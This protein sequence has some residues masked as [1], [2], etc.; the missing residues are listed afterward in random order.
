M[1]KKQVSPIEGMQN[2]GTPRWIKWFLGF[3][4][5][6]CIT[7]GIIL[8][9]ILPALLISLTQSTSDTTISTA[10]AGSGNT[11]TTAS[12]TV[13]NTGS[14]TVSVRYTIL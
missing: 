7:S 6:L 12:S 14:G 10:I 8:A 2:S 5:C 3:G 11:S 9:G 1:I 13:A 4:V